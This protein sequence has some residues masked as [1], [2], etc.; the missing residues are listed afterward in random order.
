MALSN[1]LANNQFVINLSDNKSV[2]ESATVSQSFHAAGEQQIHF[3]TT[4]DRVRLPAPLPAQGQPR[5]KAAK[6]LSHLEFALNGTGRAVRSYLSS[7][8]IFKP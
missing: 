7:A 6:C 5:V 2:V 8:K 3:C 1:Q 4:D